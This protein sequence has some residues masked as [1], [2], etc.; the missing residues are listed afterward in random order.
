[1][2]YCENCKV[3]VKPEGGFSVFWFIVLMIPFVLFLWL[4]YLFYYL[5]KGDL[6][7]MCGSKTLKYKPIETPQQEAY[8]NWLHREKVKLSENILRIKPP[9]IKLKY[10]SYCGDRIKV[11]LEYCSYC[12][13]KQ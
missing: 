6:C 2:R 10:C 3:F 11:V 8:D 1:M 13:A 4:I 9:T 7:P 12:G 5:N